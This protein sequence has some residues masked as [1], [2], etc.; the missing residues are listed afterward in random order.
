M[1]DPVNPDLARTLINI[2][3]KSG[4]DYPTGPG[5]I[6]TTSKVQRLTPSGALFALYNLMPTEMVKYGSL[7]TLD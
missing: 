4:Y 5:A 6:R 7:R 2:I 1:G 3:R